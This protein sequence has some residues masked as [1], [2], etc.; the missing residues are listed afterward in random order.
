MIR[1]KKKIDCNEWRSRSEGWDIRVMW[2]KRWVSARKVVQ[3][4]ENV[5]GPK[6]SDGTRMNGV[7]LHFKR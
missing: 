7:E 4:R 5:M 3:V 1:K 2:F 6:R